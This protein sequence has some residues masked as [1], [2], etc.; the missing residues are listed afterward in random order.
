MVMLWVGVT[1]NGAKEDD[2]GGQVR[3]FDSIK[4]SQMCGLKAIC[5]F[6]YAV[7]TTRWNSYPKTPNPYSLCIAFQAYEVVVLGRSKSRN[8]GDKAEDRTEK[9]W[10]S[11]LDAIRIPYLEYSS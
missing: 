4:T 5:E 10:W 2:G 7:L 11:G 9:S 1:H 3:L 8:L 6:R